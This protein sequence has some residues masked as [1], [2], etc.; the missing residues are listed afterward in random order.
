MAIQ[1]RFLVIP[2]KEVPVGFGECYVLA[3]ASIRTQSSQACIVTG[4]SVIRVSPRITVMVEP[5]TRRL[6]C[7]Q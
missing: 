7:V 6:P 2:E 1:Y 4:S 3:S 5:L